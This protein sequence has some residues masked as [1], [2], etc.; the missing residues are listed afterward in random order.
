MVAFYLEN[1]C[2]HEAAQLDQSFYS[3]FLRLSTQTFVGRTVEIAVLS[4]PCVHL[5]WSY[6]DIGD[7]VMSILQRCHRQSA[8][9]CFSHGNC[10]TQD[11]LA[12]PIR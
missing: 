6:F 12:S 7:N 3:G 5:T 8:E 2:R 10:H 11:T 9:C 4:S 1:Q